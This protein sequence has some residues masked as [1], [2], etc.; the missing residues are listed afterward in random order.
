MNILDAMS[1]RDLTRIDPFSLAIF[2]FSF[3]FISHCPGAS[4]RACRSLNR[5]IVALEPEPD[6]YE[7]VLLPL[8]PAPEEVESSERR[9]PD[10]L[11]PRKRTSQTDDDEVEKKV[12]PRRKCK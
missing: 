2:S 9:E 1:L 6:L 10:P 7:E 3:L 12:A 8:I 4:I 11:V 5:H